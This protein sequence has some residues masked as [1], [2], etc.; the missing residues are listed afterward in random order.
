MSFERL[1]ACLCC[2]SA[3]LIGVLDLGRQPLASAYHEGD[4]V[5]QPAYPLE[6]NV[7]RRCA[8]GQLSVAVDPVQRARNDLFVCGTTIAIRN[9][10]RELARSAL[11]FVGVPDPAADR[12]HATRV[13]DVG[14]S[15]GA[16]LEELN[17]LGCDLVGVDRSPALRRIARSKDLRVL[18]AMWG[19]EALAEL[20]RSGAGPFD[21]IFAANVL[22]HVNDPLAFLRACT[23]ALVPGGTIVVEVPYARGAVRPRHEL[24]LPHHEQ[25]SHFVLRS[26]AVLAKRAA[27]EVKHFEET[28]LHGG[29]LRLY[30]GEPDRAPTHCAAAYVLMDH[31]R[32]RGLHDVGT[33]GTVQSRIE[34]GGRALVRLLEDVREAGR[35]PIG[36]GASAQGNVLMNA[37]DLGLDHVVDDDPLKWSYRVPGTDTPILAPQTLADEE[38]PVAIVVLAWTAF[39]EVRRKV[40][41]LRGRKRDD[42]FVLCVPTLKEVPTWA[43]PVLVDP[44]GACLSAEELAS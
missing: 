12:A 20:N 22:A 2:G 31:E 36:Y 15:D 6:L 29:T 24:D 34:R 38:R 35:K 40:M 33:Y 13:L 10:L 25:V 21:L 43:P 14:C 39:D 19:P 28:S 8:H 1:Q 27:L 23:D 17:V 30:L 16:L 37:F 42:T 44:P 5:V 9:H 7:C 18:E 4:G 3:E 26:F 32:E 11:A 41:S